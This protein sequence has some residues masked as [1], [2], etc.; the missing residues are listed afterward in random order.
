[1]AAGPT[2]PFFGVFILKEKFNETRFIKLPP[3]P[4]YC[5]ETEGMTNYF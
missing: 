1:M 2:S 5:W 3:I 4:W